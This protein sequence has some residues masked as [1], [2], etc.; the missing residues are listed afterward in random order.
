[1]DSI[2]WKLRVWAWLE[3]HRDRLVKWAFP[4]IAVIA[5]CVYWPIR[6][7]LT[8]QEGR[9]VV[10]ASTMTVTLLVL[11]F[12]IGYGADYLIFKRYLVNKPKWVQ[13]GAFAC[14]TLVLFGYLKL[15]GYDVRFL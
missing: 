14:V 6:E 15:M 1:M 8:E 9:A 10:I 5:A 2:D 11:L 7:M 3:N 13:W 12:I 4:V